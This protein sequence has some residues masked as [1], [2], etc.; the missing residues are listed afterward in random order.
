MQK[1]SSSRCKKNQNVIFLDAKFFQYLTCRKVFNSKSNALYFFQSNIWRVVKT[2]NQNLRRFENFNSKSDKF[3]N[4]FSEIWFLS[5]FSDSD[6]MM[7]SSVNSI[8]NLFQRGVLKE[9]ARY[10]VS[11]QMDK[12]KLPH[13]NSSLNGWGIALWQHTIFIEVT[14]RILWSIKYSRSAV[15]LRIHLCEN[16]RKRSLV[17]IPS[18]FSNVFVWATRRRTIERSWH[19]HSIYPILAAGRYVPKS[20][21][22]SK[23]TM[24]NR[25]SNFKTCVAQNLP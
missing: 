4:F 22:L 19:L 14:D 9:N 10:R 25:K 16:K 11:R 6:W 24:R 1:M 20:W 7:T 13:V 5:C 21:H 12:W 23:L 18:I 2:S 17:R 15:F 3:Q 8:T